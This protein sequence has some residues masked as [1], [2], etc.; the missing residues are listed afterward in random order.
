ML[1]RSNLFTEEDVPL[2]PEQI[3]LLQFKLPKGSFP[4]GKYTLVALADALDDDVPLE[5]AQ[6]EVELK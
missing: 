6:L 3:R 2:F 5:A 4:V 1:F